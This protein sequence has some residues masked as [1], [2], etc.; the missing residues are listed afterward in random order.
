MNPLNL[1]ISPYAVYSLLLTEDILRYI[2]GAGGIY[3]LVNIALAVRLASRKIR[4]KNPPK[5]QI[6]REIFASI[7]TML[8]FATVGFITLSGA[9][10]G[11]FQLYFDI[12][13]YGTGYLVFSTIV[14]IVLHDGYF[15]WAHRVLHRPKVFRA[16]HKLHHLSN[17]PTPFT[18]FTFNIGEAVANAV[19]LPL[20]L[21][22]MPFHP[23]AIFIFSN[24]MMLRNAIGHSGYELFPANRNGRP[25]FDWMTTV[26]HHDIHHA[27]F[28][29][30]YGL[31]FT[32]W[33]RWMGT[34]HPTYHDQFG[35]AIR[36]KARLKA[37]Q[38]PAAE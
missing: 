25:M 8:I 17:N 34:E 4:A 16:A 29:S 31:Y 26:T 3:L 28:N 7:R 15:Y 19:F 32:W 33:D 11:I 14:L 27:R 22:V 24:H 10:A 18:S 21:L 20:L 38:A 1:D 13:T 12:D 2:I 35:D 5:G 36:S 6:G 9:E 30:N 23:L 37:V